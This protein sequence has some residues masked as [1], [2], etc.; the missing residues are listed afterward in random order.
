M[1]VLARPV[2]FT[3]LPYPPARISERGRRLPRAIGRETGTGRIQVAAGAAL[4]AAAERTGRAIECLLLSLT[5]DEMRGLARLDDADGRLQA[6]I[7]G[8]QILVRHGLNAALAGRALGIASRADAQKLRRLAKLDPRVL[9]ACQER[10]LTA[11]HARWL[12]GVDPAEALAR[13]MGLTEAQAQGRGRGL[14]PTVADLK[15]MAQPSSRSR[16]NVRANADTNPT[17][18]QEAARISE[19]LAAPIHLAWGPDG[20]ALQIG[21]ADVESLAGVLER[22]GQF[23]VAPPA[24]GTGGMRFVT[25]PLASLDELAYLVGTADG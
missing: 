25:L 20:G 4:I 9:A 12:L 10:G 1:R 23:G 7:A 24:R 21:F 6:D 19:V 16:Q 18:A 11:N 17:L 13:V 15:A 14:K 3:D 2:E 5:D 22:L 8:M